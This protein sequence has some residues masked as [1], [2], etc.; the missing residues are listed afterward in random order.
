[1]TTEIELQR[2]LRIRLEGAGLR[3]YDFAPQ[4]ADGASLATFPYVEIGFLIATEWDTNSELGMSVTAR[5]HTY[6]RSGSTAETRAI[7]GV[8]YG[9]LH[10]QTFT[11]SGTN[12][13]L[14]M[15]E[16]SDC[17]RMPD[18]SFHGVCEYRS[19]IE[20]L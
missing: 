14:T 9:S 12:M 4:S 10:R 7:Q 18:G 6:S 20:T 19:L 3:V 16:M 8:I 1:M 5:I 17:S 15:R 2:A 11:V 13:I